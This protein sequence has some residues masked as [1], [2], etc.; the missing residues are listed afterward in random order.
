MVPAPRM[1]RLALLAAAVTLLASGCKSE[2]R[3]LAEVLCQC[4]LNSVDQANCLTAAGT[5]EGAN[6]PTPEDN[7]RCQELLPQP[8][9]GGCDC[10]LID[11]PAGKVRCGLARPPPN[12]GD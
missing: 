3:Q 6:P 1:R 2:C 10:R 4:S 11:T 5:A 9:G 12:G 7:N 8:D